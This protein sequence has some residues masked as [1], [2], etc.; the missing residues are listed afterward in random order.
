MLLSQRLTTALVAASHDVRRLSA[1][2]PVAGAVAIAGVALVGHDGGV[3]RAPNRSVALASLLSQA[4]GLGCVEEDVVW[5]SGPRGIHGTV[6]G[7]AKALVRATAHGEPADLY[8]VDTRLSPEGKLVDV[9]DTCN[10]TRTTGVDEGRPIFRGLLIAFP[11]SID[12]IFTGIHTLDM[13]AGPPPSTLTSPA[14]SAG[15]RR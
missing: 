7:G 8:L 11:T 4:R 12:G 5:L 15:R 6:L 14:F 2:R 10:V 9:G 3:H 13:N 1:W